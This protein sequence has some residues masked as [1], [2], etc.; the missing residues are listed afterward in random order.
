MDA[1]KQ[2]VGCNARI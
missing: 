2:A 1:Q